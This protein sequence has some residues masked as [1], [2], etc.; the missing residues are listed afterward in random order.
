MGFFVLWGR[1]GR[2]A[3]TGDCKS[4]HTGSIPVADSNLVVLYNLYGD[5]R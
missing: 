5:V 4:P 3:Y 2:M 1:Y